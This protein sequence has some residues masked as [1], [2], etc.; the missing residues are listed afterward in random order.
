M[1]LLIF[2][3]RITL[4]LPLFKVSGELDFCRK[5]IFFSNAVVYSK[6][7]LKKLFIVVLL[8]LSGVF[9]INVSDLEYKTSVLCSQAKSPDASF[10]VNYSTQT[11]SEDVS[12][13]PVSSGTSTENH[14]LSFSFFENDEDDELI[15]FKKNTSNTNYFFC[16][17]FSQ[18][19]DR[20]L[21]YSRKNFSSHQFFHC[22][23]SCLYI[24]FQ[25]FRI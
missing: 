19:Q 23:L 2:G 21:N 4:G 25:V 6:V 5:L 18:F 14:D 13:K 1:N 24:L 8:L 17:P 3:T 7:I 16:F 10:Y 15:S 9:T 22:N 12:F 11:A 20:F